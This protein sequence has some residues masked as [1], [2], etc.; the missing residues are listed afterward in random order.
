[1]YNAFTPCVTVLTVTVFQ[2]TNQTWWTSTHQ[3]RTKLHLVIAS[4]SGSGMPKAANNPDH[5]RHDK[6]AAATTN[7]DKCSRSPTRICFM[8]NR[9]MTQSK[10][11]RS[12]LAERAVL[13]VLDLIMF[14][15][16]TQGTIQPRHQ[17][18]F[19][20]LSE[21]HHVSYGSLGMVPQLN[22]N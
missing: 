1:M 7:G 20:A 5:H 22:P 11:Q 4:E 10:R 6:Q 13:L 21:R 18:P 14:D 3:V 12:L 15:L 16:G 17:D 9:A 8:H 19:H 2:K